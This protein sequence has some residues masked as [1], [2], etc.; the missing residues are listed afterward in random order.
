[1]IHCH[2]KKISFRISWKVFPRVSSNLSS[3]LHDNVNTENRAKFDHLNH[4]WF[5][6]LKVEIV[7]FFLIFWSVADAMLFI[8][9]EAFL[10]EEMGQG[11][12]VRVRSP[13]LLEALPKDITRPHCFS[14]ESAE[15][16]FSK[17]TGPLRCASPS[18]TTPSL[19]AGALC[20]GLGA[21]AP[22][23]SC[24][25]HSHNNSKPFPLSPTRRGG[26]CF[27]R[28]LAVSSCLR[29]LS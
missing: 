3:Y 25:H 6:F 1:M 8:Q 14:T 17:L 9:P 5:F 13:L 4:A 21:R 7:L 24:P 22:R 27:L 15:S 16:R 23:L 20:R 2:R 11:P 18:S 28:L 12:H 29:V 10:P 26:S 19:L